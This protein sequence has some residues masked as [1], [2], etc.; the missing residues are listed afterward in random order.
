MIPCYDEDGSLLT[1]SLREAHDVR[2]EGGLGRSRIPVPVEFCVNPTCVNY[3]W[4][5]LLATGP[6]ARK[7]A[8]CGQVMKR[9]EV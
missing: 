5:P 7:C 8:G 6:Q 3:P 1:L 2:R 9:E 4:P